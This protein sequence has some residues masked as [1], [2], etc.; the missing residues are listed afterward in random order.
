MTV[1][2]IAP[3]DTEGIRLATPS[4]DAAIRSLLRR[5]VMSGAVRVA[6]TREPSYAA[7]EG[8]AGANDA[9]VVWEREGSLTAM[10]RCSVRTLYRNEVPTRVAYLGELRFDPAQRSAARGMRRGYE[11]LADFANAAGA[12]GCFTSIAEDNS[13]ARL[14]LEH[15]GRLGLPAYRSL[16]QLVTLLMPVHRGSHGV[17]TETPNDTDEITSFLD[18]HARRHHLSL[19]WDHD[20]W[21]AFARHG[22]EP[23]TFVVV[24]EGGRIV[25]AAAL[26]DQRAF[27]QT[28][29]DGYSGGV[30]LVRPALNILRTVGGLAALPA[31]GAAVAYGSIVG[32]A[33]ESPSQWPALWRA[34]SYRAGQMGLAW[35]SVARDATDPEL[36]VLR[37]L[38]RSRE[39][40][41]TLYDVAWPDR[42][43]WPEPWSA[44][45]AR[46]EVGLL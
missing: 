15:G 13:R 4:D 8:L 40:R 22:I 27:R 25:A 24:R 1:M 10:G 36:P 43:R 9:T 3:A 42:A 44:G 30:P 31:P 5:S 19:T 28:I 12:E 45:T 23:R 35:L 46:P 34:L 6:F 39:Y 26:W 18:R 41:T 29:I 11:L 32:A 2:T 21:S 17:S 7:G 37:R 14:V 20:R 33:V 38:R 16:F